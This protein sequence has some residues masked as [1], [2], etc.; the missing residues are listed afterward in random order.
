MTTAATFQLPLSFRRIH[1]ELARE[2]DH[3]DG[4]GAIGYELLAPLLPDCRIDPDEWRKNREA[5]R[6]VRI[7]PGQEHEIGHLVRRPGGSWAFRYVGTADEAGYH[8]GEER[9]VPG[10]YVSVREGDAQHTFKVITAQRL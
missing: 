6:V 7:R 8:F 5:C 3:P 2:P 1:L 9:F 4:S 10:E